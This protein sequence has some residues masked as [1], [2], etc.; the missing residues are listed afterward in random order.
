MAARQDIWK[1]CNFSPLVPLL[2]DARMG[3]EFARIY[4]IRPVDPDEADFYEQNLYPAEEAVVRIVSHAVSR[5][6]AESSFGTWRENGGFRTFERLRAGLTGLPRW[7][8]LKRGLLTD[9]PGTTHECTPVRRK[10][11]RLLR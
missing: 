10:G 7:N 4:C 2:I 8:S 3:A 6:A 1:R 9:D 5:D 11:G